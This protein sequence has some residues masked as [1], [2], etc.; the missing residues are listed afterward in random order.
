[1]MEGSMLDVAV[2]G[3]EAEVV[4]GGEE[5]VEDVEGGF[6]FSLIDLFFFSMI[7]LSCTSYLTLYE[8]ILL[9]H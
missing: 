1:M 6:I 8:F 3:E 5:E 9:E 2:G 4:D 7:D